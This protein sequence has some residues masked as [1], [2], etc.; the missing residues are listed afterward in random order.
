M[1]WEYIFDFKEKLLPEKTQKVIGGVGAQSEEGKTKATGSEGLV[2]SENLNNQ[3]LVW[4]RALLLF[5]QTQPSALNPSIF[6]SLQS[7]GDLHRDEGEGGEL[8][9]KPAVNQL[10]FWFVNVTMNLY[11]RIYAAK[12]YKSTK[13]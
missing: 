13:L 9:P 4:A 10:I 5:T 3:Y 12:T 7:I 1:T 2:D 6:R 8:H 11:W